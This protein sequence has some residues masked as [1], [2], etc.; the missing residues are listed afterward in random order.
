MDDLDDDGIG[1]E[2]EEEDPGNFEELFGVELSMEV[3]EIRD[4]ARCLLGAEAEGGYGAAPMQRVCHDIPK[5]LLLVAQY[6]IARE[7]F[8]Q[9]W[10]W[11]RDAMK[12]KGKQGR[13][14][15]AVVHER[16]TKYL[17]DALREEMRQLATGE[18]RILRAE[19]ERRGWKTVKKEP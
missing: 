1:M 6:V 2:P 10:E 7:H 3:K 8:K 5:G 13:E 12:D 9:P 16:L 18:H 17:K 4:R 19:A 14:V 11:M 15:R